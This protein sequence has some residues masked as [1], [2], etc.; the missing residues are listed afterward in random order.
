MSL[1]PCQQRYATNVSNNNGKQIKQMVRYIQAGRV[2]WHKV[3]NKTAYTHTHTP[4]EPSHTRK[5]K[6]K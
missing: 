1:N 3:R 2:K 4:L 5:R 6:G